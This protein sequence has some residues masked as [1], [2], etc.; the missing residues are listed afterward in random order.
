MILLMKKMFFRFFLFFTRKYINYSSLFRLNWGGSYSLG[1][2][3]AEDRDVG[4]SNPPCPTFFLR[5]RLTLYKSN[6][7]LNKDPSK[8]VYV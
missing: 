1:E 8:I 7:Y 4:G 2:H 5:V 6:I 3:T